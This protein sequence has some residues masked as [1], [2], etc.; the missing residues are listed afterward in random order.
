MDEQ[1]LQLSVA[2][3]SIVGSIVL[4]LISGTIGLMV[5]SITLILD[6]SASL[7]ILVSGFLMHFTTK[8]VFQPPDDS[9]HFGYDK[10][11]PL[12]ASVQSG[13][14]IATCVISVFF[15]IQDIIHPDDTTS[16]SIPAVATFIAG[17][18]GVGIVLYL[19]G[20]RRKTDSHMIRTAGLHWVIDTVLS[21]CVCAGFFFGFLLQMGGYNR[22]TPYV[23]PVMSI[24]LALFFVATPVKSGILYLFELLDAAPN[25]E[26][27]GRVKKVVD[28]YRPKSSGV[29]SLRIRK[30]GHRIFVDICFLV[31][32]DFTFKQA[33]E[34]S[35]D[36][37]RDLKMELP[38]CDVVVSIKSK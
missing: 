35:R 31:R 27:R 1:K 19:K 24:I 2:R 3:I 15:A 8:K 22:I 9:Y 33:E 28:L 5:D 26:I 23:D 4:F 13:L 6:A 34:L 7:V 17:M 20:V 30:A 10:Y 29:Q 36:F 38:H 16:Y 18:I 11:E 14:I 25:E 37:E 12:T 21:F 32:E